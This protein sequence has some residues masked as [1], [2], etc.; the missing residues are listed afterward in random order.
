MRAKVCVNFQKTKF[1]VLKRLFSNLR[2]AK[3][4]LSFR[5]RKI[6]PV[7]GLEQFSFFWFGMVKFN[8]IAKQIFMY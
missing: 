2:I 1:P 4:T 6:Y 5:F 7:E 8:L 3:K